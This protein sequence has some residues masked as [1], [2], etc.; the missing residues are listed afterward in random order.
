MAYGTISADVIQSSVTG[1]S[2]GAGNATVF[3]NRIINGNM[4]IDQRNAGASITPTVNGTYDVDRF[5]LDLSVAS[6]FSMQQNQGSVTLPA[7]F[8]NY[9]GLTSLSAYS[10][11]AGDYFIL[12]QAIE[13]FNTADLNWG[14]ANAKTVTLSFWVYSSVTGTQSGSLC[15]AAQNRSYPFT[16]TV[17]S[18]NTW[19]QISITVAGDTTGTW[20]GATNGVGIW[21]N[22]NMGCG[23]TYL[24]TAG[25]WGAAAYFGATSSVSLVG[26]S[27]ATFYI[28]GVQLEVGSS[29]TGFE[30]VDYGTQL[31]TLCQ[32]YFYQGVLS[33]SGSVGSST[34]C[35]AYTKF[36]QIMRTTPT[37][38]WISGGRFGN[39]ASDAAITGLNSSIGGTTG[40]AILN[41]ACSV[42]SATQGAVMY[43]SPIFSL[44][45]EL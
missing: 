17:S 8:T 21:V 32:R 12:R 26:T 35:Y 18:A 25:A 22:W 16:F 3:K 41:M 14:T 28:T 34:I 2:L 5:R 37:I 20:I 40:D 33:G 24:G 42:G 39:G 9:Q 29:A 4:V 10:S 30:Y 31:N 19:T 7:G 45:A 38:S 36:P 6:K 27:G 44:S 13:G 11:A 15:N 1:V 23:S 43:A